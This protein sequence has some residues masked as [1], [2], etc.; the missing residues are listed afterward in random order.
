MGQAEHVRS[1]P[2]NSDVNLFR[3]GKGVIDLDA[4]VLDGAFDLCVPE[5]KLH[6]AQVAVR[7]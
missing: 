6:G 2:A 1:A 3:Y 5:Q 7:W 4:E